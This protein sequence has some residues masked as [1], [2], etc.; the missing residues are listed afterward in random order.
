MKE[1]DTKNIKNKYLYLVFLF[2][3]SIVTG[4]NLMIHPEETNVW[5][6]RGVGFVYFLS[7]V[8]YMLQIC[9]KYLNGKIEKQQA[10]LK[11]LE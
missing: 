10:I 9:A 11:D 7:G 1:L 6:I 3:I 2:L 5:I 4:V 8:G